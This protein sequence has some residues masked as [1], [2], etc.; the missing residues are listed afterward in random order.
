MQ[1]QTHFL[2]TAALGHLG[3]RRA[4][5]AAHTPALLIGSVL[6]D[7]P[8]ALLTV[9]YSAYYRWIAPLGPGVDVH[10]LLHFSLFYTD[11]I[12]IIGHNTLHS[13]V[14]TGLLALAGTLAGRQGRRWG[15]VL[16]WF[17]LGAGFH[18]AIDIVTHHSDGPLFLFPLSWSYRFASPFSYWEP[19]YYGATVRLI[20]YALSAI[21]VLYLIVSW[22]TRR[23][24]R[25]PSSAHPKRHN[26][27]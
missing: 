24:D 20:E 10:D 1:T 14:I 13:L 22:F 9:L 5:H 17:A 2:I 25:D 12:W 6:P 21:S 11:P 19:A 26:G 8:F 4:A 23:R 27:A 3:Q 15:W 16:L 7:V 18:T